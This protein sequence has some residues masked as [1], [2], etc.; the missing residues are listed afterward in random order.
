MGFKK[1]QGGRHKGSVNKRTRNIEEMAA[2]CSVD[3]FQVLLWVAEGNWKALGYDAPSK[4]SYTSA[5]IEFEEPN[6]KLDD[7]I[8][9]AKAASKYLYSEKKAVELGT[10][11]SAIRIEIVDYVSEKK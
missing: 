6:V 1:G 2:A 8:S 10:G 7:R 4:I 11:E 5:G 9:A 3:P